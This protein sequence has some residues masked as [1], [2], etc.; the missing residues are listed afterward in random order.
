MRVRPS[1]PARRGEPAP[2]ELCVRLVV[3]VGAHPML[4]LTVARVLMIVLDELQ[5]DHVPLR[6]LELG[7]DG[8]LPQRVPGR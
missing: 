2:G 1:C 5:A 6:R 8:P 7:L 3:T 4:E